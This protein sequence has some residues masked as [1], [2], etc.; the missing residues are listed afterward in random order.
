MQMCCHALRGCPL[1]TPPGSPE[2]DSV[3]DSLGCLATTFCWAPTFGVLAAP[4]FGIAAGV[5]ACVDVYH[6]GKLEKQQHKLNRL[7]QAQDE[8]IAEGKSHLN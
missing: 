1:E 4:F 2:N 5:S 3:S 7:S 6:L 8:L